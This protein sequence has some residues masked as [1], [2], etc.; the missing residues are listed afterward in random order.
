VFTKIDVTY[1][2][3]DV[4]TR[5]LSHRVYHELR[6]EL[7]SKLFLLLSFIT[8]NKV[9]IHEE[10][11][12]ANNR[13]D[14]AWINGHNLQLFWYSGIKNFFELF[15]LWWIRWYPGFNHWSLPSSRTNACKEANG[16]FFLSKF[17]IIYPAYL[18]V[19]YSKICIALLCSVFADP[20][21]FAG[22]PSELFCCFTTE[23]HR[24]RPCTQ[25]RRK[26]MPRFKNGYDL[27]LCA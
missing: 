12:I 26:W 7:L 22:F 25:A 1:E 14:I 4:E 24:S 3:S 27:Y 2:W 19:L 17:A 23:K 6:N 20:V 8:T 15:L 13:F 11:S 9:E 16:F 10:T 21:T 18:N 5:N